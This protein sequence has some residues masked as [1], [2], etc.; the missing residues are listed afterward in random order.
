M[1]P[2]HDLASFGEDVGKIRSKQDHQSPLFVQSIPAVLKMVEAVPLCNIILHT[3]FLL[4][5]ASQSW[6]YA[7]ALI[8][9]FIKAT[10][11]RVMYYTFG[12]KLLLLPNKQYEAK[13]QKQTFKS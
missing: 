11:Y 4:N 13:V 12:T 2:P 10:V 8:L 3:L 5:T 1:L 9:Y 7:A 6:N